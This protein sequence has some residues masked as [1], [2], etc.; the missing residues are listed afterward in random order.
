MTS[1]DY[2]QAQPQPQPRPRVGF[3]TAVKNWAKNMFKFS[4]RAS[5][6]EFWWVWLL[7]ILVPI[8]VVV[9]LQF[10]GEHVF[11]SYG[12]WQYA[13]GPGELHTQ[14]YEKSNGAF[15]I[16][17]AIIL[18]FLLPL[19]GIL[20]IA[21]GVRRLHD[22]NLSGWFY[23]LI[24][25]PVGGLALLIMELLPGKPE[26]ARFDAPQRPMQQYGQHPQAPG[27]DVN[28]PVS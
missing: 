5:R 11:P 25:I 28:Q 15:M 2:A 22:A 23:L 13:T 1:M 12:E 8:I 7:L 10:L 3:G 17:A 14:R 24:L 4:G 21:L 20:I 26:G 9:V 19:F 18:L 6:S 27:P 16:P